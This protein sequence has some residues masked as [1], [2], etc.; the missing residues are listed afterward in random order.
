M[1]K[2]SEIFQLHNQ[3]ERVTPMDEIPF[4]ARKKVKLPNGEWQTIDTRRCYTFHPEYRGD[5][6]EEGAY[7]ECIDLAVDEL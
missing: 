3:G 6:F 4:E 7:L 5:G 2:M 1:I